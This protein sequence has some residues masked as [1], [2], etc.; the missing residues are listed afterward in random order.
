PCTEQ[1][2]QAT[3]KLELMRCELEVMRGRVDALLAERDRMIQPLERD[4]G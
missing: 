2:D 1:Y 4:A 3:Q